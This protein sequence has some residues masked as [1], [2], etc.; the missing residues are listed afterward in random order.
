MNTK[1]KPQGENHFQRIC[2]Y[3][4]SSDA[5]SEVYTR[6]AAELGRQMAHEGIGAVFG[7][8]RTGM[9]GALADAMRAEDAEVIGVIPEFFNTPE[10]GHNGLTEMIVTDTM[11]ARKA[12]MA[13]LAD[14][15]IALPGGLGTFEELF[16]ILTWAQIGLHT[17]PVGVLNVEGYYDPLLELIEH[18]RIN[19]FV[20]DEHRSLLVSG[21]TAVE[22][23]AGL[24]S[25]QPPEGLD[26]WVHRDGLPSGKPD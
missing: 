15:F 13:E 14:A 9:M 25:Y 24:R 23:L 10:L 7:G 8:G 11:H 19:G 17:K 22:L 2:I 12:K 4:G 5:I 26:R 20:Y 3:G 1:G 21:S 16:E 18:S 6:A